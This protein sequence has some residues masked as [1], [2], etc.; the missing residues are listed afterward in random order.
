VVPLYR[1]GYREPSG[2]AG[3]RLLDIVECHVCIKSEY[4]WLE[5]HSKWV[6]TDVSM[7]YDRKELHTLVVQR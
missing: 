2:D 5:R 6:K 4:S 3:G 7:T 1:G